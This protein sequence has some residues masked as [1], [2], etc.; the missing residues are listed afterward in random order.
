L[1]ADPRTLRADPRTLRAGPRTLRADP[2]TLRADPRT[3]RADPRTLRADPRTLRADPRTL[4]VVPLNRAKSIIFKAGAFFAA[5]VHLL[6]KDTEVSIMDWFPTN[7]VAI[8][9]MCVMWIEVLSGALRALLGIPADVWTEF[10]DLY[11]AA[12]DW[13]EQTKDVAK[14]TPVV[15]AACQ[16]AFD[17][18]E[19]HMRYMRDRFFRMPPLTLEQW[20]AMGFFKPDKTYTTIAN[21]AGAPVVILSYGHGKF[22]LGIKM[23]PEEGTPPPSPHTRYGYSIYYGIMPPGGATLEEAASEKHYLMTAPVNG[24]GLLH[25]R[26]TRSSHATI[27]FDAKE[28]GK[29]AY[30]FVR[31]ENEKGWKSEK[32]SKVAFA[33][34]P[35]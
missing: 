25:Y 32:W 5:L 34:I 16:E 18:L 21:P 6:Y 35:G 4:P 31:Y 10:L 27:V 24:E 28:A 11:A 22:E 13:Y 19:A 9:A 23:E 17:A 15:S 1:R 3:L 14:H 2:R 26:F 30:I 29:T 7:R 33:V 12:R 20:I 8:L